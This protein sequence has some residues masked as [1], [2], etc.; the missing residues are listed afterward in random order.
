MATSLRPCMGPI[1]ALYVGPIWV[2]YMVFIWALCGHA[3]KELVSVSSLVF[4][5]L[6]GCT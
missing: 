2:L 5:S 6:I 4:I 1:W 3:G